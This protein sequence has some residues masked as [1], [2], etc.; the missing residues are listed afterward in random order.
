MHVFGKF[1]YAFNTTQLFLFDSYT[2]LTRISVATLKTHY[3]GVNRYETV[4][5][6]IADTS[7]T[8]RDSMKLITTI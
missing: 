4:F 8:Y 2:K 5:M 7:V 6:I 3:R 1:L